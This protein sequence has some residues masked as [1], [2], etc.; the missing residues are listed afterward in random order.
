MSSGKV[1]GKSFLKGID[2]FKSLEALVAL[3]LLLGSI[4][5]VPFEPGKKCNDR[6]S[7]DNEASDCI[8]E[9]F[10]FKCSHALSPRQRA[11]SVLFTTF[12][13]GMR[14]PGGASISNQ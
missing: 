12:A 7:K 5:V 8:V 4:F 14:R 2:R 13:T 6:K 10:F 1:S 3:K 11:S 9:S